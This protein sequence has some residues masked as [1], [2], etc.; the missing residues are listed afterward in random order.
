MII[1]RSSYISQK[2]N[3]V[4]GVPLTRLCITLVR[5]QT[6]GTVKKGILSRT[7]WSKPT[8]SAY[9]SQMPRLFMTRVLGFTSLCATPTFM[10]RSKRKRHLQ[11]KIKNKT[12]IYLLVMPLRFINNARHT[13]K[14]LSFLSLY[15]NVFYLIAQLSLQAPAPSLASAA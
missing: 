8:P 2:Q 11:Q 5:V 1:Y 3:T 12:I 15:C 9:V 14:C 4:R 10:I 7:M 6:T 13:L